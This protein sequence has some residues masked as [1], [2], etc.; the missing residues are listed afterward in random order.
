M[1]ASPKE[2]Q[3]DFQGEYIGEGAT[4]GVTEVVVGATLDFL[5]PLIF[6]L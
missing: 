3:I 2:I 5:K 4:G 6:I 1:Y